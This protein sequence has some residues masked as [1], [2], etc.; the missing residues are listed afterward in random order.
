M[1]S[2]YSNTRVYKFKNF[3]IKC[4]FFLLLEKRSDWEP[5]TP[6]QSSNHSVT[7]L[8]FHCRYSL[9][10]FWQAANVRHP[11]K[12]EPEEPRLLRVTELAGGEDHS[13]VY[14]QLRPQVSLGLPC[15]RCQQMPQ[16]DP[17]E[18][19]TG[20]R[21]SVSQ[22]LQHIIGACGG[23]WLTLLEQRM[24]FQLPSTPA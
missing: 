16:I 15:R 24:E 23:E 2:A 21:E 3:T 19:P 17:H 10:R 1:T 8:F 22:K 11:S 14:W 13:L 18:E 6:A 7:R 9:R 20:R 5:N 4:L 12:T